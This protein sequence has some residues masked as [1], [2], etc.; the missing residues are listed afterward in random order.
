MIITPSRSAPAI[1]VRGL[2]KSFGEV[3]ALDGVDLEAAPGTVLGCARPERRRQDHRRPGA[4]HPAGPGRG[5]RPGGRARRGAGRRAAAGPHRPGRAVR[6]HR[7]QPHRR[8]EPRHGRPPLRRAAALGPPAGARAARALR[9]RRRGRPRGQDLLG[10]HAAA[11]GS[12]GGAGGPPARAV[13][14]RAHHGPR[15]PQ[16]AR[17]LGDDRGSG[18]RR[19]H[20]A[21]HHPVPRR[22]RPAG[23]PHR[24]HRPRPGDR[25]RHVGPAQGPRGR[26]A[27]GGQAHPPGGLVRRHVGARRHGRRLAPERGR[28]RPRD[29]QRPRGGDHGGGPPPGR[30][31]RRGARTSWCAGRRS[32]TCSCRSPGMPRRP[33]TSDEEVAA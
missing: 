25:R 12:R 7:R 5:Q 10:R 28:P 29:R 18:G 31:R 19:H 6:G 17:P 23:R 4:H 26:R 8:G 11:A 20:R 9:P 21:A 13:P 32:T 27:R 1:S 2:V 3:R 22:G 33:R 16:P 30:S 15:P 14:G 24:G